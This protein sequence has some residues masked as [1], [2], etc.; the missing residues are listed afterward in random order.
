MTKEHFSLYSEVHSVLGVFCFRYSELLKYLGL[1]N[2]CITA[3]LVT[4]LVF[5][6]FIH[7]LDFF[8]LGFECVLLFLMD[9]PF[10]LMVHGSL[11][12]LSKNAT[13]FGLQ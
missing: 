8:C 10:Q 4:I 13:H 12:Q 5:H 11:F 6:I 3:H 2:I 9:P 1:L 7:K